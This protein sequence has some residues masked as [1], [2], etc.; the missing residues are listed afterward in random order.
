MVPVPVVPGQTRGFEGEHRTHLLQADRGHQPLESGTRNPPRSGPSQILVHHFHTAP[1]QGAGPVRQLVLPALALQV[2]MDLAERRLADVNVGGSL[3]VLGRDLGRDHETSSPAS[4]P[5]RRS[6]CSPSSWIHSLQ[7]LRPNLRRKGLPMDAP[8]AQGQKRLSSFHGKSPDAG[9]AGSSKSTE[10]GSP[11]SIWA[12]RRR[13]RA[14]SAETETVGDET[15]TNS[16]PLLA[17][18][19]VIHSGTSVLVPSGRTTTKLASPPR[20]WRPQ[21]SNS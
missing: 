14:P 4:E 16:V 6:R 3:Q 8:E 13:L 15:K 1:A 12:S 11:R 9:T 2:L 7:H 10:E 19:C 17:S 20:T 18:T 5:S 21:T